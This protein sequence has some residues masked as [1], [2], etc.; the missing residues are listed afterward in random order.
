M[1]KGIIY[2]ARAG[3]GKS[4][5]ITQKLAD[6]FKGKS[7]LFLT[8]TNQNSENLRQKLLKSSIA[9]KSWTIQTFYRFLYCV[10][11]KPCRYFI[12]E[13][14]NLLPIKGVFFRSQK[15]VGEAKKNKI[16]NWHRQFWQNKAGY[17][18]GDKLA[19]LITDDRYNEEWQRA[20][21]MLNFFYDYIVIDEFQDI[22]KPEL[23]VVVNL[24][25]AF[26][27]ENTNIKLIMVGDVY[28][29]FVVGT[30][31]GYHPYEYLEEEK[32]EDF[33]RNHLGFR[34]RYMDL[35]METLSSTYRV[36]ETICKYIRE[37]LKI[38]I[39]GMKNNSK[40]VIK[41]KDKNFVTDKLVT[42]PNIT[43]LTDNRIAQDKLH[44]QYNVDYSEM[45]NVGVSK[46]A[47]FSKVAILLT[48]EQEKF[49]EGRGNKLKP[50][51]LNKLYVAITRSKNEVYLLS[52]NLLK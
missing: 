6:K 31:S 32:E 13:N 11:V 22:V 15:E 29:S 49:I 33:I 34:K 38:K 4:T 50:K 21:R 46:G 35:D 39:Y 10:F 41:V 45:M 20:V 52:N 28:Q 16:G 25:K 51:S 26:F 23:N 5:Y 12:Q 17:L 47:E 18:Y 14:F 8:F 19:A 7:V 43:F 48:K 27:K 9:F 3:A 44:N 30:A 40:Q 37:K 42:N 1:A 2:S 24:N 36:D